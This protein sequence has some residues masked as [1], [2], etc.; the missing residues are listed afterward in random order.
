[1]VFFVLYCKVEFEN[2]VSVEFFVG[3]YYCFD[4]KDF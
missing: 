1:M 3:Y 4:V 2:V